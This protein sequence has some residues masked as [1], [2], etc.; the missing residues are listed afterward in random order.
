MPRG[1]FELHLNLDHSAEPI[2]VG[3]VGRE[4]CWIGGCVGCLAE[5]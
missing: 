2:N 4:G 5:D 3:S 1:H